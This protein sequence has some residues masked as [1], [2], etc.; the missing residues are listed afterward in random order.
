MVHVGA[1]RPAL[2]LAQSA[3]PRAIGLR[4][5]RTASLEKKFPREMRSQ[6][7]TKALEP[8]EWFEPSPAFRLSRPSWVQQMHRE[9][10]GVTGKFAGTQSSGLNPGFSRKAASR[11]AAFG[12]PALARS[13][14]QRFH[15]DV[16]RASRG[17]RHSSHSIPPLSRKNDAF[18]RPDDSPSRRLAQGKACA[19][20]QNV[21]RLKPQMRR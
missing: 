1:L 21:T 8:E 3:R 4:P 10:L 20:V 11:S 2:F 15:S 12:D 13:T 5:A 7:K 16:W 18:I 17:L 6:P 19:P 14:T 9:I